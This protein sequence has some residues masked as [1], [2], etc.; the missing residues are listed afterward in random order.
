[1]C[2]FRNGKESKPDDSVQ[3][4]WPSYREF[5]K[6]W[7]VGGELGHEIKRQGYRPDH[8]CEKTGSFPFC[9]KYEALCWSF[10]LYRPMS[11]E[12][13]FSMLRKATGKSDDKWYPILGLSVGSTYSRAAGV[14][15][16]FLKSKTCTIVEASLRKKYKI[17]NTILG[18]GPWSS[19]ALMLE[20]PYL[21]N[22]CT[23]APCLKGTASP[24][25]PLTVTLRETSQSGQIFWY[26]KNSQKSGCLWEVSLILK[27]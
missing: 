3:K 20:F 18:Q 12:N 5:T 10:C 13:Y 26:F 23:S 1:M 16:G 4:C 8:I 22:I 9:L 25:L 15:P 6:S 17:T 14:D 24:Q 27:Y 2:L 21:Y 11:S 19:W 7:I